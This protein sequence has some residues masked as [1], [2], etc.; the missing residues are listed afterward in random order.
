MRPLAALRRLFGNSDRSTQLLAEIREGIANMTDVMNRGNERSEQLLS[1]IGE[2]IANMTNVG[3]QRKTG[4]Q[5]TS[6]M[7][8]SVQ[9]ALERSAFSESAYLGIAPDVNIPSVQIDAQN[10]NTVKEIINS[11][12]HR[13]ATKLFLGHPFWSGSI[14]SYESISLIYSLVRNFQPE[15]VLEIGAF[16]GRTAFAIGH[17][18]HANGIGMHHTLGPY[19]SHHFLPDYD[20]WPEE[21]RRHVN[22]YPINSA[23]FFS[24][25][26]NE[27]LR[28]DI[29]F[30]DGN[31]D[32]EYALFD[33]LAGA[34]RIT[35]GGFIIVDNISQAGPMLAVLDFLKS[36][37]DWIDCGIDPTP[38]FPTKAYDIGRTTIPLIDFMVIR[39]PDFYI[40]ND[41]PSTFGTKRWPTNTVRGVEF[42]GVSEEIFC[43]CVLRSFGPEMLYEVVAEGTGTGRVEFSEPLVVA[44]NDH[45]QVEIWSVSPNKPIRIYALPTAF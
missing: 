4:K 2:G 20:R 11:E 36:N 38:E 45:Y 18:M 40:I 22:F 1:E 31:H 42:A 28:F 15:Q 29:I 12:E 10:P 6:R 26:K 16:K 13:R 7:E 14:V 9:E 30:V 32:Y 43:Q 41:R 27:N 39:A 37:P 34:R 5:E 8:L 24:D 44:E 33:I 3:S 17:A 23:E 35:P 21:I 19:D 25:P